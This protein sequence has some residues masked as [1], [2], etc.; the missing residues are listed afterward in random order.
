MR[1]SSSVVD[2]SPWPIEQ[3]DLGPLPLAEPDQG[4]G[5]GVLAL[6]AR[7]EPGGVLVEA[8]AP[9]DL[10]QVVVAD[11][12]VVGRRSLAVLDQEAAPLA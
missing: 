3:G 11:H 8:V 5:H 2:G 12:D 7:L 9:R 6:E 4:R 1:G 10:E